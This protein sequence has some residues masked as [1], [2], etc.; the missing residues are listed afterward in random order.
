MYADRNHLRDHAFKVRLN[1]DE[2]ALLKE[3]ARF[4]RTQPSVLLREIFLEELTK[5][6]SAP[7][8]L[9]LTA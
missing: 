7:D 2:A 8:Q 6:K 4:N 5:A 3:L 1:E 9:R